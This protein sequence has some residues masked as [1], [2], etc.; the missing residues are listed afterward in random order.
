[1]ICPVGF[2]AE[3]AVPGYADSAPRSNRGLRLNGR[4]FGVLCIAVFIIALPKM[5]VFFAGTVPLYLSVLVGEALA[6]IGWA[7]A[8]R[9]ANRRLSA[10]ALG[11]LVVSFLIWTGHFL[12]YLGAPYGSLRGGAKMLFNFLPITGF[13]LIFYVTAKPSMLAPAL[14]YTRYGFYFLLIYAALQLVFGADNVAIQYVTA[15]YETDFEEIIRKS[16]VIYRLGG[17]TFKLFGTYQNGNLFSIALILLAPVALLAETKLW[18]AV[19][20]FGFLHV[21]ILF[22]ASTTSYISLAILDVIFAI[23]IPRL[24]PY[25]PLM[26]VVA[27]VVGAVAIR[28]YCPQQSCGAVKLLQAKLF[29]R[30]LT[31]NLRWIKTGLWFERIGA[32]VLILFVGE[33]S[34]DVMTIFEVLPFS[35]AQY[36]GVIVLVLFYAVLLAALRPWKFEVYKAGFITYLV[37]SFGSGGF[38]LTPIPYLLGFLLGVIILLD[39]R[40]KESA[41]NFQPTFAF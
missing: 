25:L 4:N 18:R 38:W 41:Q 2:R 9:T 37:S 28:L 24:R 23:S 33:M 29:Q 21:V 6:L 36:Y 32:G 20:A 31:D 8:V 13:G 3:R 39:N 5:G 14:K 34:S 30:D 35:I 26:I 22:S 27:I 16:N 12:A 15:N 11:L 19:V 7:H 1:M 40:E 10:L 17:E